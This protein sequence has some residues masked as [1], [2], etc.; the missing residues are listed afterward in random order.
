MTPLLF[1]STL[2]AA[3]P[4]ASAPEELGRVAWLRSMPAAVARAKASGKPI[5]LLFDEVPGCATVK[6]FGRAVLS[7]PL[8]VEALE[9]EFVPLAVYNNTRGDADRALLEAFGE[10]AW[11]NPVVRVI[12]PERAPLAPRFAGPYDVP[13]FA[14]TLTRALEAA[15]RPVPEYL[16]LLALEP[17]AAKTASYSMYCF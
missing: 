8:V 3:A 12:T 10:P 11:N 16:A 7:H 1:T 15:G 14:R 5:A 2:L 17:R 4:A 9:T 6:G 13:S